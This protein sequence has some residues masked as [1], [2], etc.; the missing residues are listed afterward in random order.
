[1]DNSG[2]IVRD[3]PTWKKALFVFGAAWVCATSVL[4]TFVLVLGPSG[5]DGGVYIST[6]LVALFMAVLIG[7]MVRTR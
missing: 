4:G 1:M 5:I 2:S 7:R 6:V 3:S